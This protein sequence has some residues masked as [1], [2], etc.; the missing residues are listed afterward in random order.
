MATDQST[1][2]PRYGSDSCQCFTTKCA[3]TCAQRARNGRRQSESDE[4]EDYETDEEMSIENEPEQVMDRLSAPDNEDG[5]SS[6]D[7]GDDLNADYIPHESTDNELSVFAIKA[8]T[9]KKKRPL[10]YVNSSDDDDD[11]DDNKH[12]W[13][14][15]KDLSLY[16]DWVALRHAG[17][18]K[19]KPKRSDNL[20][21]VYKI[22]HDIPDEES[23]WPNQLKSLLTDQII[24]DG[25]TSKH[26]WGRPPYALQATLSK[27]P[28]YTR[29]AAFTPRAS[30]ALRR[31]ESWF[32]KLT[33]TAAIILDL[34]TIEN[35]AIPAKV[36]G[37]HNKYFRQTLS[38]NSMTHPGFFIFLQSV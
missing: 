6:D 33:K 20:L 24:G 27:A 29:D 1:Q 37:P 35:W 17:W 19:Q 30:E 26:P 18:A 10:Q 31:L 28:V 7:L 11:D 34:N 21:E 38:A 3:T 22:P 9:Q 23:K 16:G 12:E 5:T 36:R 25:D 32:I 8:A 13:E 14:L 15:P 2:R 4:P